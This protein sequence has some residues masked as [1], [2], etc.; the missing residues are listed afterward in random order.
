MKKILFIAIAFFVLSLCSIFNGESLAVEEFSNNVTNMED[1]N[2]NIEENVEEKVDVPSGEQL[3]SGDGK[4]IINF[5]KEGIFVN[6]GAIEKDITKE[7]Y[8]SK[9]INDGN[10]DVI[11]VEN[12]INIA[13]P[14][15]YNFSGE[16][17]D[18]QISVNSNVIS[19]DVIIELNDVD[20]TCENAPVILI[21]NNFQKE[22]TC[23]ITIKTVNNTINNLKGSNLQKKIKK[24][25]YNEKY[26]FCL[27]TF[28]DSQNNNFDGYKY[29]GAISSDIPVVFDG[30]GITII[31]GEKDA[32]EVK[33]SFTLNGGEYR[34]YPKE[35]GLHVT[36]FG[37]S[38][39]INDGIIIAESS[40]VGERGDG[41]VSAGY[42]YINSG[43]VYSLANTIDQASKGINGK[44]GVFINGGRI[45]TTGNAYDKFSEESKQFVL[46]LPMYNTI[47]EGA[48]IT[49]LDKDGNPITAFSARRKYK[50]LTI[51]IPEISGDEYTYYLGGSIKGEVKAGL[52]KTITEYKIGKE[53]KENAEGTFSVSGEI[54]PTTEKIS[55]NI[56][57]GLAVVIIGVVFFIITMLI[58]LAKKKRGENI[59]AV[60]GAIAGISIVII[61][62]GLYVCMIEG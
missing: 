62:L 13:A 31:N 22:N 21:Y 49:I 50:F 59:G 60:G 32:I 19:G 6:G 24:Q 33:K 41:I 26:E 10:M 3:I 1:V 27:G 55:I 20:I 18:G 7:I 12:I 40:Y 29:D 37:E 48:L 57:N 44:L 45:A 30:N 2:E 46:T 11:S 28:Y 56:G 8:L 39:T 16:L 58:V 23:N 5:R 53:I 47:N 38:I 54:V 35:D 34:L 15:V 17:E 42:I 51:S 43:E 14:G 25:N 52:F 9:K 4:Y 36:Q 61:L